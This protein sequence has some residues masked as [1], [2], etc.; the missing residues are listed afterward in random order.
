MFLFE[1]SSIATYRNRLYDLGQRHGPFPCYGQN[2]ANG[3]GENL[4]VTNINTCNKINT[5]VGPP[6]REIGLPLNSSFL[7]ETK[8]PPFGQH[9]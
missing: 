2:K 5:K 9:H 3:A 6:N 1:K 7:Y 4:N 8:R